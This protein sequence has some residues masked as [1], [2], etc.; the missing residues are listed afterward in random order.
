MS[1]L[2]TSIFDIGDRI[3]MESL[4]HRLKRNQ[5]LN[6]N[7]ANT[8]TPGFRAMGYSFEKH[9]QETY[10]VSVSGASLKKENSGHLS[11]NKTDSNKPSVF[12]RPSES[13]G[14]DGNT[15]DLDKE[16]AQLAKNQIFLVLRK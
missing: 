16:M 5:V 13:V 12:I 11:R 9:L 10:D 15:V 4:G 6:S 7:I 1:S 14:N 3:Q 2:F 8:E